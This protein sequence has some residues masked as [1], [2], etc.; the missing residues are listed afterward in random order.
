MIAPVEDEQKNFNEE[1]ESCQTGF[2]EA[3]FARLSLIIERINIEKPV[4]SA[5]RWT[6]VF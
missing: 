3:S 6:I 5:E 2:C 4:V 1:N